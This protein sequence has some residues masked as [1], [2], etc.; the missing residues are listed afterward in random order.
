MFTGVFWRIQDGENSRLDIQEV[1]VGDAD[2]SDEG[3]LLGG[4]G[5]SHDGGGWED[6][7]DKS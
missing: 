1:E 7:D 3:A 6:L 5:R 2:L 4:G